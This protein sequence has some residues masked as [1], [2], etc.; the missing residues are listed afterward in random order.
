MA[1]QL[2]LNLLRVF[3]ALLD[4]RSVTAAAAR[5]HLSAP[6]TSRALG[7]LRRSMNDQILVRAGRGLVPTPFAQRSAARVKALLEEASGLRADPT[8]NDPRSWQRTF[9][10]R[11]NDGLAPVLAPRLT[12][13]V[14]AEAPQVRLRFVAQDSKEADPLRDGSLDLDVGVAGPPPPDLRTEPLFA[15]HFV[16]LMSAHSALGRAERLTIDDLCAHP[17]ISASRRGLARGPLDEALHRLGRSR[18]VSAVV[19]SY[20]VAAL[21]A[22]E[23]NVIC[24]APLFLAQHLVARHVPLRWHTIPLPLPSA[25]VELR[26]HH[27]VDTDP[28]SRW[29]R[30]H[31]RSAA[32][33]LTTPEARA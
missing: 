19:P 1:E 5:L 14:A 33:P 2:D 17:H 7:R 29:L 3:D 12:R 8:D 26:W 18:T 32:Q 23:E 28:A 13:L 24:L 9:A 31:M 11:V 6:A 4:T 20:A 25:T 27:R 22:L 21:M 15:D 30:A 16:A 10:I